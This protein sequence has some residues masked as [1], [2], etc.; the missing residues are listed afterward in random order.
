MMKLRIEYPKH[1][2]EREI[3]DRMSSLDIPTPDSVISL[4]EI[5]EVQRT[6]QEVYVDDRIKE[7]ILQIVF[8]TREPK[9]YGLDLAG[10]IQYGASPRASIF[11][12]QAARAHAFIRGRGFVTPEDIKAIGPDV[13]RHRILLTYEAEAEEVTSDGIIQQIFDAVEVP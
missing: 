5:L 10:L 8:A 13:L 11:L 7:Y 1:K 6:V 2:E 3:L 12:L 9:E 4:E